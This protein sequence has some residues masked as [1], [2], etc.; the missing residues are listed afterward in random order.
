MVVHDSKVKMRYNLLRKN[1]ITPLKKNDK[2]HI[3]LSNYY[4]IDNG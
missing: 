1:I 4:L 3:P 2:I